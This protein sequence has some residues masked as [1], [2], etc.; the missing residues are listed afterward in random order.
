MGRPP[1]CHCHCGAA[2]PPSPGGGGCPDC[3][4]HHAQY[5]TDTLEKILVIQVCN[6]NSSQDDTFQVFLNGEQIDAALE[7]GF[8]SKVGSIYK[9]HA[10]T[11]INDNDPLLLCQ[12]QSHFQGPLSQ[13]ALLAY[14][15]GNVITANQVVDNGS[16]NFGGIRVISYDY[17][18]SSGVGCIVEDFDYGDA[19]DWNYSFDLC[20]EPNLVYASGDTSGGSF[21][22]TFVINV[23]DPLENLEYKD[24]ILHPVEST[25]RTAGTSLT[26]NLVSTNL[27][28]RPSWTDW[29]IKIG[30]GVWQSTGVET[31][32]PLVYTMPNDDFYIYP[33]QVISR[34]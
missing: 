17:P 1:D 29:R 20:E 9:T 14:P 3:P 5:Q 22:Y 27:P 34:V 7:L 25:P 4:G 19:P 28:V 13:T 21:P 31:D 2:L 11:T 6:T 23:S 33:L 18:Y 16:G 26:F 10:S 24:D 15:S 8:P 12:G 32:T 30:S